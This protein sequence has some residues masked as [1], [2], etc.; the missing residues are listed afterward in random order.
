[1][2]NIARLMVLVA[3]AGVMICCGCS[4]NDAKKNRKNANQNSLLASLKDTDILLRIGTNEF[5][6][7]EFLRMCALR[8]RFLELV[9]QNMVQKLAKGID[10]NVI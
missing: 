4:K 3:I 1:M 10:P 5:T 6:K 2:N 7:A 9:K 8:Q